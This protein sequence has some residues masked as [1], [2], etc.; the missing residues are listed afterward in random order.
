[1]KF[2][3]T[4]QSIKDVLLIEPTIHPDDR[5]YFKESYNLAD[6]EEFLPGVNFVQDNESKSDKGVVRGLHFQKK[7]YTQAKLIRAVSGSIWDIAVDIRVN[8]L[9]YKQFVSV[10]LSAN[11]HLQLYVPKGFAHGFVALG[12]VNI[13]QYKTDEYYY[14]ESEGGIHP[15]DPELKIPWP[16]DVGECVFSEKDTALPTL[17]EVKNNIH[18]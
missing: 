3:V 16:F 11:N 10:E 6:F 7:P 4:P 17:S 8:S 12:N 18:L 1:M 14:P 9:T 15:Y 5:G 13:V 2:K